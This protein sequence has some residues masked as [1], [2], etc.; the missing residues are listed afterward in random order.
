MADTKITDLTALTGAGTATGD[1]IAIVDV[2]ATATKKQTVAEHIL[3][4]D[5]LRVPTNTYTQ[6]FITADR[7]IANATATALTVTDGT[8]TNNGTIDAITDNAST[9][10]AVQELAAAILKLI[11][12]DADMRQAIT[13]IIDDLQLVKIVG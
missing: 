7:T 5:A 9:I 6:T 4:L 11:A 13:A 2:S 1:A 12:D 8:G 10:A 3:A